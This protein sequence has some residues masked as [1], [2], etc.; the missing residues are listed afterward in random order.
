L[1][2]LNFSFKKTYFK[3]IEFYGGSSQK[4]TFE[5]FNWFDVKGPSEAAHENAQKTPTTF[6]SR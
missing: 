5:N 6:L 4:H 3:K 2:R 1:C